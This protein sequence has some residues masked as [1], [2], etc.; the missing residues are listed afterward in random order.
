MRYTLEEIIQQMGEARKVLED[1]ET[2]ELYLSCL[3]EMAGEIISDMLTEASSA[4]ELLAKWSGTPWHYKR[5]QKALEA[6]ALDVLP[7]GSQIDIY[8]PSEPWSA[9]TISAWCPIPGDDAERDTKFL[10]SFMPLTLA[11]RV[12]GRYRYQVREG[13]NNE[14]R[15]FPAFNE[16]LDACYDVAEVKRERDAAIMAAIEKA[17]EI[18]GERSLGLNTLNVV[19]DSISHRL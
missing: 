12:D 1:S 14:P 5:L 3:T 15:D 10:G 8:A 16:L 17:R 4:P 6:A 19:L 18:R 11:G 2:K 7:E 13:S 9:V